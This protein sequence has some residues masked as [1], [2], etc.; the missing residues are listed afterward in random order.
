MAGASDSRYVFTADSV[1]G[2]ARVH[3]VGGCPHGRGGP[4]GTFGNLEGAQRAAHA[5]PFEPCVQLCRLCRPK[6]PALYRAQSRCLCGSVF[7]V[8]TFSRY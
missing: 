7:P 6:M 8:G 1:T 4:E 5:L 3:L 2:M